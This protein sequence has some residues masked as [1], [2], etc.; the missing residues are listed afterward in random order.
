MASEQNVRELKNKLD[1]LVAEKFGGDYR[2][3]FD[4]YDADHDGNISK[5][6]LKK[7]LGDAG[8][9]NMFT[10]VAWAGGIIGELDTDDDVCISWAEF[11]A[12]F[13]AA[14]H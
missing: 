2:R 3:A 12:A 4:G 7:L 5:A 10:R 13:A 9:G 6:E 11:E 1:A 14:P 8:V